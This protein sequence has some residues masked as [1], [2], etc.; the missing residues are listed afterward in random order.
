MADNIIVACPSCHK[1]N[2]VVTD[3]PRSEAKCGVC[4]ASLFP[5]K[6]FA[7]NADE[8]RVHR[9]SDLP[10]VVDFWASWCG[11]CKQFAPIFEQV[12]QQYAE[13]ARFVKVSTESEPHLAQHFMIRSIPTLM[14]VKNGQEVA[15]QA[16]AMGPAQLVQWLN[17]HL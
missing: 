17:Q 2:R 1:K 4:K 11:P 9:D 6:A 8:F 13:K 16:G 14:V 5:G 15:R 10:L 12:A 3:K 7:V